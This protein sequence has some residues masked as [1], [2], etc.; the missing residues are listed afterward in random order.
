LKGLEL[1]VF[2]ANYPAWLVLEIGADSL[3]PQY[4]SKLTK[5][6]KPDIAVFTSFAKIPVHVEFFGSRENL[7]KEKM[8][9]LEA[10][11]REGTVI[12]NFDDQELFEAAKALETNLLSFGFTGGAVMASQYKVMTEQ[13]GNGTVPVGISFKASTT[14]D[15]AMIAVTGSL[16]RQQV[17]PMLAALSVGQVL[18]LKFADMAAALAAHDGPRGRM[19]LIQGIKGATII[20]DTYNSSPVAVAEGLETLKHIPDVNRK[21]AMLGDMMELGKH[22]GEAHREIGVLAAK[23]VDMLVAVG[24]RSR[25]MAEAAIDA[26]LSEKNV[27]QFDDSQEAGAFVQNHIEAGDVVLIKGSQSTR[28]ERAVKEIMAEPL[29]AAEL[30]VRQEQEWEDR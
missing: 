8:A 22:S 18:G 9:V 7:F 2:K 27:F 23:S 29:R 15:H 20:D 16:G 21:I 11:K 24:I 4:I 6:V 25:R 26:G 1:I 12:V 13:S 17:Y 14:D 5:W 10:V 30:L 3:D 28:M 19:K